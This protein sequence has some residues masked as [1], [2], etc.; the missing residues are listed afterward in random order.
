M[1]SLDHDFLLKLKDNY[2]NY[3]TFIETGSYKG[4]TI[5]AME[6]YFDTLITIEVKEELYY[7]L[8]TNYDNNK[9]KFINGDSVEVFNY[10]FKYINDKCIFFLDGHYSSGITGFKN[11]TV[12]L[13]DE[14]NLINT[15]FKNEGI[16][17]IDDVRLFGKKLGSEDWSEINKDK[18]FEILFDR[19]T[20]YYYLESDLDTQDRL[21]IHIKNII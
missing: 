2:K 14:I 9:I 10:L 11:K 8:V 5:F 21:I 18:I 3:S 15:N 7:N 4:E 19:I 13:L 17:I 12:P 6:Q 16:I 1:P 20:E